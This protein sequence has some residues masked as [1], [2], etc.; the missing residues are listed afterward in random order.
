VD[1][2]AKRGET[3]K[4]G[5]TKEHMHLNLNMLPSVDESA[6]ARTIIHEASH[7]FAAMPGTIEYK[8]GTVRNEMYEEFSRYQNQKPQHARACADSYAWAALSL[9]HGHVVC[10]TVRWEDPATNL[11]NNTFDNVTGCSH[12][13]CRNAKLIR[14]VMGPRKSFSDSRRSGG[15]ARVG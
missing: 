7:M 4:H 10:S 11:F 14:K 15:L 6:I 5:R 3:M 9:A 12:E 8:D 13:K 1:L 2:G